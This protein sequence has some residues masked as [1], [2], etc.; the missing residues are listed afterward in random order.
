MKYH[1]HLIEV[2][3]VAMIAGCGVEQVSTPLPQPVPQPQLFFIRQS[4]PGYKRQSTL[5]VGLPQAVD[6]VGIVHLTTLDSGVNT[7]RSSTAAG[8]FAAV[9]EAGEG[10]EFELRFEN[11]D[12]ISEPVLLAAGVPSAGPSLDSV[13]TNGPPIVSAPDAQG[14]VT[15]TNGTDPGARQVMATPES[16]ILITNETQGEITVSVTDDTGGF[17]AVI[18][19]AIGD[20]IHLLLVDPVATSQTSDFLTFEVPPS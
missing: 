12:G 9:L 1:H 19:G 13:D 16:E 20:V 8:S 3:L 17:A 10:A 6:G 14:Q 5:I 2:L 11:D 4:T 7:T 18:P 15:V